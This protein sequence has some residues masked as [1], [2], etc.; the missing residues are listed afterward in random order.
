M[1][2]EKVID[3]NTRKPP[4]NSEEIMATAMHLIHICDAR[5]IVALMATLLHDVDGIPLLL[6]AP[7]TREVRE[8]ISEI[9]E[10]AVKDLDRLADSFKSPETIL[11]PRRSIT[12]DEDV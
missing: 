5:E 9:L 7:D 2:D 8:A 10:K 4:F 6:G 1:A 12:F 3:I 11:K